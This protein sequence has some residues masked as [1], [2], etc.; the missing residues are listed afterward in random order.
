MLFLAGLYL[1]VATLF[2]V[3]LCRAAAR[4]DGR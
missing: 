2:V 3:G 1:I 4:G